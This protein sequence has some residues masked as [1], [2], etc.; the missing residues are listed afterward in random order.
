ME[1]YRTCSSPDKNILSPNNFVNNLNNFVLNPREKKF[2]IA[3]WQNF[4]I[5]FRTNV[6]S[7]NRV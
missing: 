4:G 7:G 2:T 5:G 3:P 6:N 1:N